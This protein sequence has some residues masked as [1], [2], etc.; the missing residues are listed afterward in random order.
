MSFREPLFR[1]VFV[2][3]AAEKMGERD[4]AAHGI[5]PAVLNVAR[6][7]EVQAE[8]HLRRHDLDA[9]G[10]P[11]RLYA[12]REPEWNGNTELALTNFRDVVDDQKDAVGN[13][14]ATVTTLHADLLSVREWDRR[15]KIRLQVE[16][17]VPA[18]LYE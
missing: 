6:R 13:L 15:E 7:I 16:R 18:V 12:D 14:D 9:R 10:E 17:T 2:A 1:A 8:A 4:G 11:G 5:E 3:I